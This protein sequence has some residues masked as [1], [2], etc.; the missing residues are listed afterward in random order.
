MPGL[1]FANHA[2]AGPQC[3][4]E[5]VAPEQQPGDGNNAGAVAGSQPKLQRDVNTGVDHTMVQLHMHTGLRAAPG[6][7]LFISYGEKSNEELLML[8][9][10]AVQVRKQVLEGEWRRPGIMQSSTM[11]FPK[12]CP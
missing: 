2:I 10:F 9:G 3:W 7:E 11:N 4:W 1:D 6:E 5:V 12:F 8:Y